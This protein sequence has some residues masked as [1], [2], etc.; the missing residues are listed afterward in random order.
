[1][2]DYDDGGW[3]KTI[4]KKACG[5]VLPEKQLTVFGV[6]CLEKDKKKEK[7]LKLNFNIPF[8]DD[9]GAGS[10]QQGIDTTEK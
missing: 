9:A 2:S 6:V 5:V 1:M 7:W 3:F 10:T 8:K 4:I